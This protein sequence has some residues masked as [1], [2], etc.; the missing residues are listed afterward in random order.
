[1]WLHKKRKVQRYHLDDRGPFNDEGT[2]VDRLRSESLSLC[3]T[4]SME[5]LG[6]ALFQ[7][8]TSSGMEPAFEAALLDV[9][10]QILRLKESR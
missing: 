7:K 10:M 4:G 5:V 9:P 8:Q 1:M 3:V 2:D 6:A